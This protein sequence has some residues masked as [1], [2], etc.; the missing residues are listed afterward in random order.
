MY[1]VTG[2][3]VHHKDHRKQSGNNT[4]PPGQNQCDLKD[5]RSKAT[6]CMDK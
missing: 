3:P 5:E 4:G 2:D 1:T 6:P